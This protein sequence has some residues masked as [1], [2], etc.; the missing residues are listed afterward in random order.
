M[1]FLDVSVLS[2]CF[3]FMVDY[4]YE[5]YEHLLSLSSTFLT[6]EKLNFYSQKV[7]MK[8]GI[9]S[10]CWGFID[11]TFRK[12]S[13]PG[14]IQ[15]VVYNGHKQGHGVKFQSVVTPDGLIIDLYGPIEGS[16]HDAFLFMK[17]QLGQRISALP[18][19]PDQKCFY[20]YGDA[21]YQGLSRDI[22][23]P[24]INPVRG[25]IEAK[26]NLEMSRV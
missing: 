8:C 15:E 9:L 21:G 17:S 11:G 22:Y 19:S 16:R 18:L 23:T 6:A 5:Q 26:F 2:R 25:S 4:L 10:E 20:L 13:Q 12:M 24:F 1:F 3:N 7:F 14:Q